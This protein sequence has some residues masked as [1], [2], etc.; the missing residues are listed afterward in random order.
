[1]SPFFTSSCDDN[2]DETEMSLLT[3]HRSLWREVALAAMFYGPVWERPS[4]LYVDIRGIC[5]RK[6]EL[7]IVH[8]KK[9]CKVEV[10]LRC[11]NMNTRLL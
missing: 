10:D 4:I 1:M 5:Q 3:S 8:T 2:D 6:R 7:K 11:N 9:P